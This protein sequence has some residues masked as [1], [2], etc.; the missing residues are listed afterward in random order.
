MCQYVKFY[1]NFNIF[2]CIK[3]IEEFLY[4]KKFKKRLAL[5]ITCDHINF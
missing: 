1:E 5:F 2:F 3:E 4:L